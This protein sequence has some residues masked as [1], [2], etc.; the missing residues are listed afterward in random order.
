[1]QAPSRRCRETTKTSPRHPGDTTKTPQR[2]H[3]DTKIAK[4]IAKQIANLDCH[5]DTIDITETPQN[6][7]NTPPRHHRNTTKT[8]LTQL[9]PKT[10]RDHRYHWDTTTAPPRDHQPP[11]QPRDAS[12]TPPK[13]HRDTSKTPPRHHWD[14]TETPPRRHW[15]SLGPRHR[16]GWQ[17]WTRRCASA[18]RVYNPKLSLVGK[19]RRC[20]SA[21][22][23]NNPKLLEEF[24]S[25]RIVILNHRLAE[26]SFILGA[27]LISFS[28]ASHIT[29]VLRTSPQCWEVPPT[30]RSR[31]MS[32]A[33]ASAAS[34]VR[35]D[36]AI[37]GPSDQVPPSWRKMPESE[38]SFRCED[39][40]QCAT[41]Q[42][43]A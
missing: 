33:N 34:T 36:L 43:T 23:V 15:K 2:H 19:T 24:L 21:F 28:F 13:H 40:Q 32:T 39:D 22:R 37:Q 42:L 1:M 18:F 7:T 4:E 41:P 38:S 10:P 35:N 29:T 16:P 30:S 11:R 12:E 8:P 6:S 25:C 26:S 20:P 3:R 9:R 31:I 5:Q 17:P 27:M 14:I